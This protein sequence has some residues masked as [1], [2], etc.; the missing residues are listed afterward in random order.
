MNP[1]SILYRGAVYVEAADALDQL[2]RQA[3]HYQDF[4]TFFDDYKNG[5]MYGRYWHITHKASFKIDPKFRPYDL[6]GLAGKGRGKKRPG[7]YVTSRPDHWSE[8]DEEYFEGRKYAAEIDIGDLAIGRDYT[9]ND[10]YKGEE[11][12]GASS[13]ILVTRTSKARV[14]SVK[15][16]AKALADFRKYQSVRPKTKAALYALWKAARKAEEAA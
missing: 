6:S 12:K 15:P 16:L 10:Y 4:A 14:V 13:E 9:Y 2:R 1:K 5:Q 3:A 8:H 11:G 7:L